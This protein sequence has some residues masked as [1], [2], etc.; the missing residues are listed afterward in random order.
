LRRISCINVVILEA[1]K[2]L[3]VVLRHADRLP[4]PAD[5]LEPKGT[6]RA[7]VLARMLQDSGV[8]HAY[9]S[10]F[11]RTAQTLKPLNDKLGGAL[12]ITRFA[13]TGPDGESHHINGIVSAVKA[14]PSRAVAV[15]V[16]H[17][18]TVG[19]I[20]AGLGGGPIDDITHGQFDKL[21]VLSVTPA[22][23]SLLKLRYGA[24]T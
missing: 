2:M 4:D 17:N 13:I 3:V 9:C 21:F 12:A 19:P 6:A 14:L 18:T 20:I 8:T 22:G 7:E 11:A 10:N 5:A 23:T 15:V 16:S 24:P 1:F